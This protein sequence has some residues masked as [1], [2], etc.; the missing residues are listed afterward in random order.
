VRTRFSTTP[1]RLPVNCVEIGEEEEGDTVD[2]V[3]K[4]GLERASSSRAGQ[5]NGTLKRLGGVN[6]TT[7]RSWSL[8]QASF[9]RRVVDVGSPSDPV[10]ASARLNCHGLLLAD[11]RWRLAPE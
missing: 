2:V 4:V 8:V 10:N 9:A 3:E 7:G 1:K 6:P 5:F 11:R